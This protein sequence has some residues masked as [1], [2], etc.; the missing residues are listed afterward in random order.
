LRFFCTLNSFLTT[1]LLSATP[2]KIH[3][4]T[5]P[6]FVSYI[7][8]YYNKGLIFFFFYFYC[9]CN[10]AA[11]LSHDFLLR[12]Q[13]G[14]LDL[15]PEDILPCRLTSIRF[16]VVSKSIMYCFLITKIFST[17]LSQNFLVMFFSYPE[18]TC[19][20]MSRILLQ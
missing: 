17:I 2:L 3:N 20:C 9:Y 4:C 5:Q 8:I 13:M 7:W 1:N 15:I 6:Y 14:N 11:N 12:K 19:L 16:F 10:I 18:I